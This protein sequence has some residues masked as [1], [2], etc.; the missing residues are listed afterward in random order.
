[1]KVAVVNE[2]AH[3]SERQTVKVL[4]WA[5]LTVSALVG[6]S[7]FVPATHRL[8]ANVDLG[9]WNLAGVFLFLGLSWIIDQLA[10]RRKST[11]SRAE[12]V[13]A[14]CVGALWGII[15]FIALVLELQTGF[16][17][18]VFAAFL[19]ASLAAVI[20]R[21]RGRQRGV[22]G[23]LKSIKIEEIRS[24]YL[25]KGFFW[26]D[27]LEEFAAAYAGKEIL[28]LHPKS[29]KTKVV[30]LFVADGFMMDRTYGAYDA[31][32]NFLGEEIAPVGDCNGHYIELL[33][34]KSGKLIGFADYLLLRWGSDD[35][36][37][38][39]SLALL[40]NGAEATQIGVIDSSN[41]STP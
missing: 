37:W 25:Q 5:I 11:F 1:M 12:S 22:S 6:S 4:F 16:R 28:Y 8:L 24:F 21:P 34:T 32:V 14:Q 20:A 40:L 18:L 30:R 7:A 9:P 41:R 26:N 17:H 29:G 10:G 27:E 15:F 13:T 33:L 31:T 3:A 35:L 38:K 39:E 36:K 2:P 19:L 23:G